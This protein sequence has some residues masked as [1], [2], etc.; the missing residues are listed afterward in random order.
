MG[1]YS[2]NWDGRNDSKELLPSGV[3]F[4]RIVTG[5]FTKSRKTILLK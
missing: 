2:V 5:K 4:Y 1:R 3:Y